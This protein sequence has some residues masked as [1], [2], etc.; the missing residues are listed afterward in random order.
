MSGAVRRAPTPPVPRRARRTQR[1]ISLYLL[2]SPLSL[3]FPP[4]TF[5][6]PRQS[7]G[8]RRAARHHLLPPPPR[9]LQ[10][11][12]RPDRYRLLGMSGP[13]R[14][15]VHPRRRPEHPNWPQEPSSAAAASPRGPQPVFEAYRAHLACHLFAPPVRQGGFQCREHLA[16][17]LDE[18]LC[19]VPS[20]PLRPRADHPHCPHV[21]PTLR[22]R[23]AEGEEGPASAGGRSWPAADPRISL[24]GGGATAR[25]SDNL[26]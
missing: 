9:S 12:G 22:P 26:P 25:R 18:P 14:L 7:R 11:G 10:S 6:D 19:V 17:P 2:W 1:P 23:G 24:F 21:T 13:R 5:P 20:L 16:T 4:F 8:P 3:P 15:G